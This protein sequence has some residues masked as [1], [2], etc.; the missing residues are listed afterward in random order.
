MW[1]C[2]LWT[3]FYPT[4]PFPQMKHCNLQLYRYFLGKCSEKLHSLFLAVLIFTAKTC[5]ATYA[6]MKHLY[7]LCILL[8]RRKFHLLGSFFP[9]TATL[10]NRLLRRYFSDSCNNLLKS[11]INCYFSYISSICKFCFLLMLIQ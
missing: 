2:E 1:L 6:E 4:N 3:I 5:Y 11:S 9:T 10:C 7:F 8:E